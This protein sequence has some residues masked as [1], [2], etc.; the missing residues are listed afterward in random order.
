MTNGP[1]TQKLFVK[2]FYYI[3]SLALKK[4]VKKT[5]FPED[6]TRTEVEIFIVLG[7][8]VGLVANNRCAKEK[9]KMYYIE[10]VKR[11]F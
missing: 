1:K 8:M 5:C 7:Y 11:V 3:Y 9:E 6:L 10:S 4:V 2:D